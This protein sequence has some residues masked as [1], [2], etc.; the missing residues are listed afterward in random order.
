MQP[1]RAQPLGR[2]V[3]ACVESAARRVEQAVD[4]GDRQHLRQA[5]AALRAVEDRGRIVAAMALGVEEADR[6]GASPTAAAPPTDDLQAAR[7]E[8]GEIAA[9]HRRSSALATMLCRAA[10]NA[11]QNRRG[12]GDRR[13]SVLAPRAALGASMSRNSA[14]RLASEVF[15]HVRA[16]RLMSFGR[17][18]AMLRRELA[19]LW[20]VDRRSRAGCGIDDVAR[21]RRPP[22]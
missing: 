10:R 3:S 11:R 22:A 12:R 16:C 7:V 6:A 4:I 17:R 8:V 2:C 15:G 14:I 9:Q 20:M 13:A 1:R 19:R 18:S 5:A 21:W